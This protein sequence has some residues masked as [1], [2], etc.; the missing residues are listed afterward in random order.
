LTD[1][2]T[3][4]IGVALG[5]ILVSFFGMGVNKVLRKREAKK[6]NADLT[7]FSEFML[8]KLEANDTKEVEAP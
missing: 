3:I 2:L 7:A 6:R 1:L 5:E 4:A 8:A